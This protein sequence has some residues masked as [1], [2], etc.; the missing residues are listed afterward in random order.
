MTQLTEISLKIQLL[1]CSQAN[2]RNVS[3]LCNSRSNDL[4]VSV[5]VIQEYAES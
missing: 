3:L 1:N 2:L 4:Q 5:N